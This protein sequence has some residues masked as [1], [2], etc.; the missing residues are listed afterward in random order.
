MCIGL[1]LTAWLTNPDAVGLGFASINLV[2]PNQ[3]EAL[4]KPASEAID[5]F[6]LVRWI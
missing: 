5:K 3:G 6:L 2:R 1:P 4:C